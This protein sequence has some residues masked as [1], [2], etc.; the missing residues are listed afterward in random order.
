MVVHKLTLVPKLIP[1]SLSGW[2]YWGMTRETV[3]GR[4][5]LAGLAGGLWPWFCPACLQRTFAFMQIHAKLRTPKV[6][7]IGG[8]MW[9]F[10]APF[11]ANYIFCPHA[12]AFALMKLCKLRNFKIL[13]LCVFL[14]WYIFVQ[15]VEKAESLPFLFRFGVFCQHP[16]YEHFHTSVVIPIRCYVL[17]FSLT[18]YFL[19]GAC[20]VY[21]RLAIYFL[22]G[23]PRMAS[24]TTLYIFILLVAQNFNI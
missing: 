12:P 21:S 18:L 9:R 4:L 3:P 20:S 1:L 22:F 5:I 13:Q 8:R 10:K 23:S 24:F 6:S 17:F 16:F 2:Y 15:R 14:W 11:L 19:S 7:I